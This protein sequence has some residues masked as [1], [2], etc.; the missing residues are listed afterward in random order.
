M[1]TSNLGLTTL[2]SAGKDMVYTTILLLD[3]GIKECIYGR[4]PL[5]S[6]LGLR[7]MSVTEKEEE[8]ETYRV[9]PRV[10]LSHPL[11]Q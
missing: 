4:T 9:S 5:G 7:V 1:I 6:I 8:Y 3:G 10:P 11:R 2:A